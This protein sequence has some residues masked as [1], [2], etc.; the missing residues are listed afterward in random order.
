[1]VETVVDY[2]ID[3]AAEVMVHV[4]VMFVYV[5]EAAQCVGRVGCDL[6]V[7]RKGDGSCDSEWCTHHRSLL[8]VRAKE[9]GWVA[10]DQR[11]EVA[12]EVIKGPPHSGNGRWSTMVTSISGNI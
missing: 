2:C 7:G 9:R 6:E 12:E 3:V 10:V 4:A 5:V 8:E 11:L 1:M